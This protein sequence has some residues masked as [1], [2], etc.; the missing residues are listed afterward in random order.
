MMS[1]TEKQAF[2]ILREDY[3]IVVLPVNKTNST[4]SIEQM[5]YDS[6]LDKLLTKT[7]IKNPHDKTFVST[8]EVH[9]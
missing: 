4:A 7:K 1:I 5:L 8:G 9:K 2:K 6:K 3:A